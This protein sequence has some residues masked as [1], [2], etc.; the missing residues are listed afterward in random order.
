M[1]PKWINIVNFLKG[2]PRKET[3][4]TIEIVD[5]FDHREEKLMRDYEEDR[6]AEE[7]DKEEWM[8]DDLDKFLNGITSYNSTP[9]YIKRALNKILYKSLQVKKYENKKRLKR[10]YWKTITEE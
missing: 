7:L 8:D 4:K 5:D 9:S 2:K 3:P 6:M 10:V 1:I